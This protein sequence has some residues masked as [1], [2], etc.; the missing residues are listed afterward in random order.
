MTYCLHTGHRNRSKILRKVFLHV[1]QGIALL[2]SANHYY[3][4]IYKP[5]AFGGFEVSASF[6]VG[7]QEVSALTPNEVGDFS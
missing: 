1:L 2:N 7:K 6:P 3:Q 4:T 5:I